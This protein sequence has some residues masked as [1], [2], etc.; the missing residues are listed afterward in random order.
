MHCGKFGSILGLLLLDV[1]STLSVVITKN[2]P[3][4]GKCPL[5]QNCLWLRTTILRDN[6]E[7]YLL[8]GIK[9]NFLDQKQNALAKIKTVKFDYIIRNSVHQKTSEE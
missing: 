2:S 1:N 7:E 4:I 3:D 9:N 8:Y 5:V 6:V